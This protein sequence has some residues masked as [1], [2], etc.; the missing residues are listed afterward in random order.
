MVLLVLSQR[1]GM[2]KGAEDTAQTQNKYFLN[3]QSG[4]SSDVSSALTTKE[5]ISV[6]RREVTTA[7]VNISQ[8]TQSLYYYFYYC[9]LPTKAQVVPLYPANQP[10]KKPCLE[11]VKEL[12]RPGKG[13]SHLLI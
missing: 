3:L 13:A 4:S 9:C 5:G 11:S 7:Q 10:F 8:G 12:A 2:H 1:S 6:F